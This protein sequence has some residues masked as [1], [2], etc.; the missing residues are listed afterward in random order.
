MRARLKR[1]FDQFHDCAGLPDAAVAQR[2]RAAGIDRNISIKPTQLGLRID[3]ELCYKN[4]RAILDE[5]KALGNF[6]RIDMEESAL[7]DTTL[8]IYHRLRAAGHRAESIGKLH[9]RSAEDD[10]G[11]SEEIVPMHIL[12]GKGGV[13]IRVT[14][15]LQVFPWSVERM[16]IARPPVGRRTMP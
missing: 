3:T 4:I 2:I 11:F 16:I 14:G 5:A 7:V 15:L 8:D 1:G 9:Y 10:N 6:V 13:A 12:N